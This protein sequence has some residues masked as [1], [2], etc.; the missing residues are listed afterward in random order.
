MQRK[1][2]LL[3]IAYPVAFVIAIVNLCFG[4]ADASDAWYKDLSKPV[5]QP[6]DIVFI[7]VWLALFALFALSMCLVSLKQQPQQAP[8][9]EPKKALIAEEQKTPVFSG[10]RERALILYTLSGILCVLWTFVFFWQHNAGGAVFLL[11]AIIITAAALYSDVRRI[12]AAAAYLLIP[13]AVWLCFLLCL[14]YE[15]AFFN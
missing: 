2:K 15:I 7:A 13:Y 14:N 12:D 8:G 11:I 9:P 6:P 4:F 10:P 5:F 1:E 3:K